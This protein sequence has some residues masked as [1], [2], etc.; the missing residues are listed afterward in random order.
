M[1]QDVRL[2]RFEHPADRAHM[3]GM[4]R[5]E[6]IATAG[7]WAGLARTPRGEASLWHHH[8]NHETVIYV[9]S[10]TRRVEFGPDGAEA[11]EAGPGDFVY[12]APATI[13]REINVGDD[14]ALSVVV[15]AG[16]GEPVINVDGSAGTDFTPDPS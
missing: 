4:V 5:E 9:L 6:A 7:L 13:H 16:S 12:V 10:G 3:S 15:R 11:V 14:E 1:S 2:I 8:G